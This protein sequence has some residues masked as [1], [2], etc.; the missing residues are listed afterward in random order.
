VREI[1]IPLPPIDEQR[2]IADILDRADAIRRKRQEA[3]RLTEELLRSAFLEMFGDPVTNPKGWEVKPLQKV[4]FNH[5]SKRIPLKESDRDKRHGEYPYYGS[6]G[7]IDYVD[8]YLFDGEYLLI[9]EDG[10]HLESRNRPLCC[11]ATGKF[12]V[13]NHAHVLSSKE[14]DL[15]FLSFFM[16]LNQIRQFVTGIDQ[17]KLNRSNLDRIPVFVP[18]LSLQNTFKEIC[19]SNQALSRAC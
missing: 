2:R 7:I 10:K 19:H 12:W 16:E 13:N 3:M 6:V 17:F 4:V 11:I 15:Q 9:S 14:V 8:D 5:D 1:E 18:P